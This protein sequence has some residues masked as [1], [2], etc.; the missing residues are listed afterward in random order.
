[1]S[2]TT[3]SPASLPP[4]SWELVSVLKRQGRVEVS[5]EWVLDYVIPHICPVCH[6]DMLFEQGLSTRSSKEAHLSHHEFCPKKTLSAYTY[7][8]MSPD[9]V[10]DRC[11]ACRQCR[12][13][14]KT[15][16]KNHDYGCPN[17]RQ[18]R[19][20]RATPTKSFEDGVCHGCL[21]MLESMF[22][23]GG[24][25]SWHHRRCPH[26]DPLN[27]KDGDDPKPRREKQ[28]RTHERLDM[29]WEADIKKFVQEQFLLGASEPPSPKRARTTPDTD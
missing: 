6:K 18:V 10:E 2:A 11:K 27:D 13:S 24:G 8:S 14:T 16:S 26:Y 1:M 22:N 23:R 25:R 3:R 21:D 9:A 17:L 12:N 4:T 28:L 29:A 15:Q 5:D 20:R 19:T 7:F